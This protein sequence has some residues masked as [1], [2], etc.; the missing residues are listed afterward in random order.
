M[1]TFQ[2]FLASLALVAGPLQAAPVISEFLTINDSSLADED[3]NFSDWIEIYNPDASPVDLS[4]YYLTDKAANL[5]LWQIPA[6]STLDPGAYMVIFASGKNRAIA[7][8][9]LHTNFKLSSAAGQYL[10]LVAPNGTTVVDDY[11]Y[12]LQDEDVSYG[13]SQQVIAVNLT[14]TSIPDILVPSAA[15]DLAVDWNTTSFV[16]GAG[17]SSGTSPVAVGYDTSEIPAPLVNI[18]LSGTASQSTSHE[19]G[20]AING[21]DGN[22]GNFTHT[23]GTDNNAWWQVTFPADQEFHEILLHNR[24]SCCANRMRDILIEVRDS[25][26]TVLYTSPLINP[27]D[28]LVSPATIPFSIVGT[29]GSPVSGRTIRVRRLPDTTTTGDNANVL[30]IGEILVMVPDPNADPED[31]S[32]E[33]NLALTGTASQSSNYNA[34]FVAGLAIDGDLGNFTHT[35]ATDSASE[36]SVDLGNRGSISEITIHNRDSCCG[37]R[38]RD[39]TVEVLDTS[40]ATTFISDLLNPG[41]TDGTPEL[42]NLDLVGLTGN[43][44]L[45]QTVKISRTPDL[46]STDA[47]ANVLSLGEVI[48]TGLPIYGYTA[49]LR[50]DIE[51]EAF[52]QNASAFVRVPFNVADPAVFDSLKLRMRYD[53]GFVA[54]LNGV[55]IANSNA[56]ASP[57]W[58]STAT[59]ERDSAQAFYFQDFDIDAH[60]GLLNTGTNVLAIHMLNL[61]ND[62]ADFLM[63]PELIATQTS[64]NSGAYLAS[65]TPGAKNNSNWYF[66]KVADTSFDFDRGFYEAPFSVAVSTLTPGAQ[67]RYTTDGSA[68]TETSGTLYS[69]PIEIT[70]T[71]VLRA[72]AFKPTFRSTDVD[73]HTYIFR[74]D[75]IASSV[76]RTSVTQNATYGPQMRD[77]LTDLPTISLAFV[78]DIDRAEKPTSVELIGFEDGNKQVNAG[79]SRFGSYVTN[80]EKRN[81]RLAFR[82]IYGPKKLRYPLYTGH[83]N[84]LRPAVEFDQLDL[85]TGSHDMNQRGFYMS[86]RFLD[87]TLLDMGHVNPHGRFIHV[88]I[89]GTYWGMYHLR[90][91][92]NADMLASYLGGQKENYEAVASNRGG[93]EFSAATPYDG[94]GS[95][96]ANVVARKSDY[97][98]LKDYLNVPQFIDFMLLLMSGDSEAEHRAVGPL[99]PGSGY[100]LYHNDGDGFTRTPPNRTGHSGPEGLLASL[101][102]EN[103]PDFRVLVADRIQKHYFNGGA[104]AS[105]P[106]VARLNKRTTQI[107]RAFLGE[108]AR[109]GYRDPANWTT[110]K[111]AYVSSTL[112]SLD[113]TMITQFRNAGLLPATV[114]PILTQHGGQVAFSYSLGLSTTS[115]GTIYYT[116]DGSD[117]RLPGGAISPTAIASNSLSIVGNTFVRARTRNGTEW[118]GLVEAFFTLSGQSALDASDIAISEI[119][120]NPTGTDESTEF[121]EILNTGTRPVNLRGTRFTAGILFDFPSQRDTIL[122]PG[123]RIVLV[124]SVFDMNALYGVGLPIAGVYDGSLNNDGELI[125]FENSVASAIAEFT[126]NDSA[127]WPSEPDGLGASLTMIAPE[128]NPDGNISLNWRASF[129]TGGTPGAADNVGTFFTGSTQE[130]LL[131]YATG[132][133]PVSSFEIQSFGLPGSLSN[134]PVISF[135]ANMRADDLLFIVEHSDDLITW[136]SGP[137]ETEIVTRADAPDGSSQLSF[138]SIP[139]VDQ[140]KFMRVRFS[141]R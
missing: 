20:P 42:I 119:H 67:I 29:N 115:A 65:P 24:D 114:A 91:R 118:S 3:G 102:A 47:D 22:T 49:F 16:P 40:G 21:I 112:T 52:G 81:I 61:T 70:S 51:T 38:L 99:G 126:Y 88:Y 132:N 105:A 63:A 54:Y 69:G 77:A 31:L 85:R 57:V 13:F 32:Q 53:D 45:G 121:I 18:A 80:F 11:T 50:D 64:V 138:R 98:T 7:G 6:T 137:G 128:G 113:Q 117:P 56:P 109:W 8:A 41:N 131:N 107:Q 44:V 101:R 83:E 55:E 12:P 94:D 127:S 89:N 103:H 71:T 75:V 33:R 134:H 104:M 133:Q 96:W 95:A 68:P 15:N 130:E 19:A 78:G 34:T 5:T 97:A 87:D 124:G 82:D 125:R 26:G 74:N 92:W 120:Y 30:A 110:T 141:L 106:A 14:G 76:M 59:V 90:E 43:A 140:R 136:T 2:T 62:D 60:L 108:A 123:Q 17:W 36:W 93:G 79:L 116:R 10:A 4:G 72:I 73:T 9:P 66:A 35:L 111:N 84:D 86:N 100:L 135:R 122:S 28:V 58:N 27:N 46:N 129:I 25:S 139:V 23:L 39:I 37:E 1:K 48:V